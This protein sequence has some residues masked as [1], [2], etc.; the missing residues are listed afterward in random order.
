[1]PAMIRVTSLVA[2]VAVAAGCPQK[3][4]SDSAAPAQSSAA[5]TAAPAASA[6]AS[7]AATAS[8][9]AAATAAASAA[10]AGKSAHHHHHKE[11][12]ANAPPPTPP[13]PL[14]APIAYQSYSN[15]RFCFTLDI[16]KGMVA[17]PPP[18]NGDGQAWHSTE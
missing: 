18:E 15:A 1:M 10:T 3:P 2:V 7:A 11:P 16:P 17:D 14:D 8:A 9:T 12:P 5:T 6:T 13:S 4:S